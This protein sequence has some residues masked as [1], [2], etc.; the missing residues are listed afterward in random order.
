M[1]AQEG[2]E[3]GVPGWLAQSVK[4]VAVGLGITNSS[5]TLSVEITLK[6]YK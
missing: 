4:H 3:R 1:E 2:K 5:L 6:N